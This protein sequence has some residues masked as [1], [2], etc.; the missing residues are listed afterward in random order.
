MNL[1]EKDLGMELLH[2]YFYATKEMK[3]E[4]QGIFRM[5]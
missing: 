3:K 2:K 1:D 4:V 5:D